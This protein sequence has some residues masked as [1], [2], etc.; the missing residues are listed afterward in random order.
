MPHCSLEIVGLNPEAIAACANAFGTLAT[1]SVI[2][3]QAV[4]REHAAFVSPAN[5]LGFMDGGI[6][7][8]LRDM[9][10]GCE[11]RL[12]AAIRQLGHT[13]ALGRAY[14][15]VGSAY[16]Q[17]VGLTTV[18]ISAPTMFLPH[19][20]SATQNAYWAFMA[21][22]MTTLELPPTIQRLVVPTLCCGWGRMSAEESARQMRR[23]YD[24][25][26]RGVRP[27]REATSVAGMVLLPSRDD[28]QPENYDTREI[29]GLRSSAGY[30]AD[31]STIREIGV[32][33]HADPR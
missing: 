2:D 15:R 30:Q 22:L 7:R 9:W 6:D 20:V 17:P 32:G 3:I 10:P 14:L 27:Q 24:D 28:E 26:L 29:A 21:V 12:K 4:R 31:P 5:S 11:P 1:C 8:P 13:T 19:D 25:F 23:A 33:E 16:W 18:L